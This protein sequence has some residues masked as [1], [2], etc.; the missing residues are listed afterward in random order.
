MICAHL[1]RQLEHHAQYTSVAAV[2]QLF[3]AARPP[4]IYKEDYVVALH[5]LYNERAPGV[6]A[7]PQATSGLKHDDV[8]GDPVPASVADAL[9]KLVIQLIT[10]ETK[11]VVDLDADFPGNHPV[12]L[13]REN[14]QRVDKKYC[15][16]WKADG[17]RYLVL[18]VMDGVYLFDR[19]GFAVRRLQLRC[20]TRGWW[21]PPVEEE[22]FKG[23]EKEYLRIKADPAQREVAKKLSRRLGELQQKR[24]VEKADQLA[25]RMLHNGTLLDGELVIDTGNVHN[26]ESSGLK[27]GEQKRRFLIFDVIAVGNSRT[28]QVHLRSEPWDKRYRMIDEHITAPRKKDMERAAAARSSYDWGSETFA[29]RKKEFYPLPKADFICKRLIGANGSGGLLPHE[30]DG[31]IFQPSREP[32]DR[33]TCRDLF[34]WKYAHMNSVD[35]RYDGGQLFVRGR[36]GQLA[37]SPDAPR[38]VDFGEENPAVYEGTTIECVPQFAEGADA[39]HLWKFHCGRGSK[40]PNFIGVYR[41]I[42]TS[43]SDAIDEHELLGVVGEIVSGAR[44]PAARAGAGG[45]D[46]RTADMKANEK[47]YDGHSNQGGDAWSKR[48][49]SKSIELKDYHNSVKRALIER[50]AAGA[51]SLLDLASGRGGDIQKWGAAKVGQVL[52]LDLSDAECK[53]AHSRYAGEQQWKKPGAAEFHQSYDIGRR[54]LDFSG[55]Q[56]KPPFDAITCMFALHYFFDKEETLRQVL[57]DVAAN[58]RPGGYFFGCLPDGERV[59]ELVEVCIGLGRIVAL[60]HRSATSYHIF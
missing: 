43:I 49:A 30:S 57:A 19:R 1:L 38:A 45:V 35:F 50:F 51:G 24:L 46:H 18:L 10:G 47:L 53:E 20:A 23:K 11:Q 6:P 32:Y 56:A 9:R 37:P 31:L 2:T 55:Y 26:A 42:M 40:A 58:L 21:L 29:M 28:G 12:S 3:A 17:T 4:G 44:S 54:P 48:N 13:D 33:G 60:Y 36:N 59:A 41:N 39:P 22:E 25:T 5:R 15:V 8:I 52:G 34:K 7:E 16:T 27:P 14:L